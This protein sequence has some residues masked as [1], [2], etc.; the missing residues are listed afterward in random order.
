MLA[1]TARD[2]FTKS[3][4]HLTLLEI[5]N[6]WTDTDFSTQWCRDNFLQYKSLV[7][8]RN[9]RDQ[10]EGL[11][12]RVEIMVSSENH[13]KEKSTKELET[14]IEKAIASGFFPNAARLSKTGDSYRSLKKNQSVHIHPSSVLH[15][16]KPPPKLLIYHELVLTS[17]E[18]MRNCLP[19]QEKWLAELAP[20][21]FNTKELEEINNNTKK[22]PKLRK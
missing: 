10:L 6:Q 15:K 21:F 1:D 3:S 5:F 14:N 12:D 17:K 4:D 16:V 22:M 7:R 20:H 8:A 19:I 11:C 9:V 18:F 13:L 2:A